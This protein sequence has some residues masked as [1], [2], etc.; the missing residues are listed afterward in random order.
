MS[1]K[2]TRRNASKTPKKRSQK[3]STVSRDKSGAV[4]SV[5]GKEFRN[6]IGLRIHS[7][8]HARSGSVTTSGHRES[9]GKL[10]CSDCSFIT[11]SA[12]S[13]ARHVRRWHDHGRTSAYGSNSQYSLRQKPCNSQV[14]FGCNTTRR[15]R[16]EMLKPNNTLS[17]K[18]N[19]RQHRNR[20]IN[21]PSPDDSTTDLQLVSYLDKMGTFN[22]SCGC[23][24]D[25]NCETCG[26][27]Y[28]QWINLARDLKEH[29]RNS[30][31]VTGNV[32]MGRKKRRKKIVS[33]GQTDC[34]VAKKKFSCKKCGFESDYSYYVARHFQRVHGKQ[35]SLL[36]SNGGLNSSNQDTSEAKEACSPVVDVPLG[37]M[38]AD[39]ITSEAI[40]K[41]NDWNNS[42]DEGEC[43][44]SSDTEPVSNLPSQ[45]CTTE[46]D[47]TSAQH[48]TNQAEDIGASADCEP[49]QSLQHECKIC[50]KQ[51]NTF[52]GMSRHTLTHTGIT[53]VR[54]GENSNTFSCS[55]CSFVATDQNTLYKHLHDKHKW[56]EVQTAS[57]GQ[58][59]YCCSKCDFTSVHRTA[60]KKH[61]RNLHGLSD[62]QIVLG[63]NTTDHVES[64]VKLVGGNDNET[65]R[66]Q[67]E[68]FNAEHL[69]ELY[70]CSAGDKDLSSK[71][72]IGLSEDESNQHVSAENDAEN[73]N[74]SQCDLLLRKN[75]IYICKI[76]R[77][78]FRKLR[79]LALHMKAHCGRKQLVDGE[80]KYCCKK[81]DFVSVHSFSMARHVLKT[82]G[83]KDLLTE[84]H[85]EILAKKHS[86]NDGVNS[87]PHTA[88]V[89]VEDLM[90]ISVNSNMCKVC[91]K[92]FTAVSSVQRHIRE[93]HQK[94]PEKDR[95][96]SRKKYRKCPYCSKCL[97]TDQALRNHIKRHDHGEQTVFQC[98]ECGQR[99]RTA[100]TLKEHQRNSHALTGNIA[101]DSKT[102][103]K[104]TMSPGQPGRT[105][106][107]VAEKKFVCKRCDFK[108]AH[109]YCVTRHYERVHGERNSPL[110]SKCGL[111]SS[112]RDMTTAN[113]ACSPAVDAS[114]GDSEADGIVI[115]D[116]D[117]PSGWY[118]L[119]EEGECL[120]SSEIEPVSNL[121]SQ[122]CTA[123][124]GITS[125]QSN[126]GQAEDIGTAADCQSDQSLPHECKICGK[127]FSTFRG[128]SIHTVA[129]TSITFVRRREN[130]ST[131]SCSVCSFVA[132]DQNTL[133]KH[134]RDK[135]Q[136]FEV[137]TAS[138]GQSVYCCSKCNFTSVHRTALKK[139]LRNLHGL[140]DLQI[141]L[142][143]N[144]TDHIEAEVKVDGN[145]NETQREQE[146]RFSTEHLEQLYECSAGDKDLSSKQSTDKLEC[147]QVGLSEDESNQHVN[148]ENDAENPNDSQ[149]DLF[150][151][152]NCIYICKICRREFQKLRGLVHHMK[153][154]CGRKQLIDGEMKYCCKKCDFVSVHSF[155]LVRHVLKSH[156]QKDLLTELHGEISG[157]QYSDNDGVNSVPHTAS[158]S[159]EDLMDI[160]VNSNMCKVCGK[161]FTA[162]TSV[163]RHIREVHQK[164]IRCRRKVENFRHKQYWKCPHCSKCLST[165]QSL[166]NHMK[167][168]DPEQ[169]VFQC[170]ECGRR[171]RTAETLNDH[172]RNSHAVMG[173]LSVDHKTRRK[174]TASPGQTDRRVAKKKFVCKRCGF[175]SAHS[176]C[177]ARHY[178]RVHRERSSVLGSRCALNSSN[179]DTTTAKEA[180]SSGADVKVSHGQTNHRVAEKKFFC[181]RCGFKSAH[182]YCVA[183]H[184]RRVHGER[185]SVL[186]SKH[187]LNSSNQSIAKANEACSLATDA[188]LVVTDA[189]GITGKAIDKPSGWN[190]STEEGKCLESSESEPVSHL[191]SPNC[192]AEED[193]TSAERITDQAEEIGTN[194]DCE[195]DQS[196][197]HECKICGKQ[198]NTFSG[199]SRHTLVHNGIT[200]VR[201]D[202]N[203]NTF[204]CSVCSFVAVDQ[205]A[206]F[207]H[208]RDQH[209][210]FEVQTASDGKSIYCCSKCDFTTVH[211]T[212]LTMHLRNLHG[213]SDLQIMLGTNTTDH[214]EAEVKLVDGNDNETECE[215]EEM[216]GMEH[217]EELYECSYGDKG[218]AL[219]ESNDKSECNQAALSEGEPDQHINAEN[220]AENP[221]DTQCDLV[222]PKNRIYTCKLCRREFRKLRGLV[223]H[224][225]AHCGRKQLIDGEMKYCCKKCDFVSVHS[226]SLVR[227][228][229][230]LH[231]QKDLLTDLHREI[232]G[233]EYSANDGLNPMSHMPSLSVE[234][235]MDISV[236]SNMCKLC[237]KKFTAV[238]SVQRHILE[239]HQRIRYAGR[240]AK[241]YRKCPHCSK[242][243]STEHALRNH[244]KRHDPDQQRVYK[245]GDCNRC[246]TNVN[247]LKQHVKTH[248]EERHFICKTCGRA[249]RTVGNLTIHE[250]I[251]SGEKP[252]CCELCGMRFRQ[253]AALQ[254]HRRRHTGEKP[255]HC[256]QC[257]KAFATSHQLK[258]HVVVMHTD[259][260]PFSCP[261]CDLT[262]GL[263]KAMRRH[264]KDRHGAEYLRETN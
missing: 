194:A 202:E 46:E 229:L 99:F 85:G 170:E 89:S 105:D 251:H 128:M 101:V 149:Y 52:K 257:G 228:V 50:G 51:F 252:L 112:N 16:N 148:A 100:E 86:D 213:F 238:S 47:I 154:H 164:N 97:S 250:L 186:G 135:H 106:H 40:D 45:S 2:L 233:K 146:E 138:E 201:K 256:S 197:P 34:R 49:D 80:M 126:T 132:A 182:S 121:S 58:T 24:K 210:C 216:F 32:S 243:L 87:M 183:R 9:T 184:F 261:V 116:I 189:D 142:G 113:E 73:P 8:L 239:V 36:G 102:Q 62:L 125:A 120:E 57:E 151:R 236:N 139:H 258:E 98:S 225:R 200:F 123:E 7:R 37:V 237:G 231:D 31:T 260:K 175:E 205:N 94:S 21:S 14:S 42:S 30:H 63:R 172:Q 203:S 176:Y 206:L 226:F 156:G 204:S 153:A 220:N 167:R 188:S 131:F 129:H 76:C 55:V 38:D 83:Q 61:L 232:I 64:Q 249:F 44:E 12:F 22:F 35:S 56:F 144:T 13:L 246:F 23:A 15:R 82:H 11:T 122:N 254:A 161:K 181:K 242:C 217:L 244:V 199:M 191:S 159:V 67:E 20:V 6:S 90:D 185:I 212:T 155:S 69:E 168:H 187:G 166:R 43:F 77:R 19:E 234:E 158:I 224:M 127:K 150:L 245:C 218:L 107:K 91:G 54:K 39:G 109:S 124:E 241:K 163:Q 227:H 171:F 70:E 103:H 81:C 248:T 140:S 71:Q 180:C 211:R 221:N 48:N 193:N 41:P 110:G 118:N 104:K 27:L 169:T 207:A 137:Q 33:P 152:K 29:Q 173:N 162:V 240:N 136:C 59:V 247:V 195:S 95:N 96:Y 3:N 264:V 68:R 262:F 75:R 157:K 177:V 72:S 133:Y 117:M 222:L 198:F 219:K 25:S 134:L 88:S 28:Q 196:L 141:M 130:L 192:V 17:V 255:F 78:E 147:S 214:I 208:L 10:T 60:L 178:Q 119:P 223:L 79:G 53:L 65:Q 263:R 143:T 108:S 160:S 74:D 230:K 1:R 114:L 253:L 18:D 111:N 26:R 5:C 190:S 165:E 215:Q 179:Q 145:D 259:S 84:L 92:K 174:K 209:V 66:E 235:L 93:V 4:C 115:E